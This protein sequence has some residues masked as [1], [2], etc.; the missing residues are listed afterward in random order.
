MVNARAGL[1]RE[2]G[3]TMIEVL[4]TIL[5]LVV[6]LL[7]LGRLQARLQTSEMESYQRAQA[8]ILAKDM[9]ARLLANRK[10]AA[11]YVT[12]APVGGSDN[13]PTLRAT[14]LD[15]DLAD[16]CESLRGAAERDAA[17]NRV[18]AMIGGRGCVAS[19]GVADEYR[20]TVAWQ[21]LVPVS[22]PSGSPGCGAGAYDGG[23]N[24]ACVNDRCRRIVST[25]V[26]VGPGT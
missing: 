7:A 8:L 21:G 17:D 10:N 9:A 20:V 11:A 26:R 18:G 4:V 19:T 16:W 25:V 13:C 12:E 2:S 24:S 1:F 15:A 6:A 22:L 23:G 14:R 5:I 3:V